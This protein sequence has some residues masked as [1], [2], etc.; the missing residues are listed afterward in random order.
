LKALTVFLSLVASVLMS[1]A[2][3]APPVL[4]EVCKPTEPCLRS[5]PPTPPSLQHESPPN[6]AVREFAAKQLVKQ[7]AKRAMGLGGG[8]A[9]D[10]IWPKP[11]DHD[12][13]WEDPAS[14]E[15]KAN[16]EKLRREAADPQR[17]F[18]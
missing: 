7:A 2:T 9:V 1:S 6:S 4:T 13:T 12:K 8:I 17:Q 14:K 3:A 16:R 11:L 5:L 18:R 10:V 15:F